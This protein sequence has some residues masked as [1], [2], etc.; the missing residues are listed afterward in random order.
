MPRA[1]RLGARCE[2]PSPAPAEDL[3]ARIPLRRHPPHALGARPCRQRVLE[4]PFR[5]SLS[6]IRSLASHHVR[7]HAS[8]DP[9][10]LRQPAAPASSQADSRVHPS[11]MIAS[12]RAL[13][14]RYSGR[15]TGNEKA[16]PQGGP[17]R[18]SGRW[19]LAV[20]SQWCWFIAGGD[21]RLISGPSPTIPKSITAL[22][23]LAPGALLDRC[24][25]RRTRPASHDSPPA[26]T[27]RPRPMPG[28]TLCQSCATVR[29][30]DAIVT[31]SP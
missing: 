8:V 19:S 15:N 2:R 26:F 22:F 6:R 16:P 17:A 30:S 20:P 12:V 10:Q 13:R 1:G 21:R 3:A 5:G 4:D 7:S 18:K 29:R 11:S 27:C 31:P 25:G 24:S 23:V 9:D 28:P 14:H